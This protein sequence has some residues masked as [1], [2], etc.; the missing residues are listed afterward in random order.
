MEVYRKYLLQAILANV[1][2][3][4]LFVLLYVA[5]PAAFM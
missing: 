5:I 2:K 3:V 1:E 4:I